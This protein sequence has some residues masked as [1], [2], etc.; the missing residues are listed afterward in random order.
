[1]VGYLARP[2]GA[3]YVN[4]KD[5]NHANTDLIIVYTL[6]PSLE[7]SFFFAWSE[8]RLTR[9]PLWLAPQ[10]HPNH[11][12]RLASLVPGMLECR[13]NPAIMFVR[14]IDYLEN[15]CKRQ[16]LL[17]PHPSDVIYPSGGII[18]LLADDI[19]SG[20]TTLAT[21]LALIAQVRCPH[22]ACPVHTSGWPIFQRKGA[23]SH[24]DHRRERSDGSG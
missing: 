14:G 7:A 15:C 17:T 11:L 16:A 1:M 24:R 2:G 9:F 5:L 3:H 10:V 23:C 13:L 21:V 6:A 12:H 22:L 4:E 18:V 20:T 19:L 8:L